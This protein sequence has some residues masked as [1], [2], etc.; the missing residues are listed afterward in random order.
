MTLDRDSPA[1]VWVSDDL[2]ILRSLERSLRGEPY[3]LLT[4]PRPSEALRWVQAHSVSLVV[5]DQRLAELDGF[6]LLDQVAHASPA[7]VRALVATDVASVFVV[8]GLWSP[9]DC[10]LGRHWEGAALRAAIRRILR[11][12]ELE[13]QSEAAEASSWTAS[14]LP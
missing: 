6:E 8:P 2:G 9:I 11:H 14:V 7:T 12:I 3:R 4:T 5:C 1:V 10:L 13:V